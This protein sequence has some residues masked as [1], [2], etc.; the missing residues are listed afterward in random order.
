M[1]RAWLVTLLSLMVVGLAPPAVGQEYGEAEAKLKCPGT[2]HAGVTITI[3]GSG[4]APGALVDVVFDV[5]LGLPAV[6]VIADLDGNFALPVTIPETTLEGTYDVS[7]SGRGRDGGKLK[8]KCSIKVTVETVVVDGVS[9]GFDRPAGPAD[10]TQWPA[11]AGAMVVVGL[12]VM[13]V[14]KR[15]LRAPSGDPQP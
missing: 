13:A 1:R 7:A 15:R 4:F 12:L 9:L 6:G 11:L 8:L 14:L 2:V 10:R 5:R 3:E